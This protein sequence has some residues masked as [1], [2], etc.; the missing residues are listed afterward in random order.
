MP[1]L[2]ESDLVSATPLTW[3]QRFE[4]VPN[5]LIAVDLARRNADLVAA[6][7]REAHVRTYSSENEW[8]EF[9][10][11][12]FYG[13]K[14]LARATYEKLK[15]RVEAGAQIHF[16]TGIPQFDESLTVLD[17]AAMKLQKRVTA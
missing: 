10:K 3:R 5:H 7:A 14:F 4:E 13:G 15:K 8:P 12:T 11:A 2:R 1:V 6:Q 9:Q 17:W 16:S